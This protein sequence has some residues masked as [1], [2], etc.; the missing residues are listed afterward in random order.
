MLA[1]WRKLYSSREVYGPLVG[2]PDSM[3]LTP[4]FWHNLTEVFQ[5][6]ETALELYLTFVE[7]G[8]TP[9]CDAICQNTTICDLR[10]FRSENNCVSAYIGS[11]APISDEL[12]GQS[13][14]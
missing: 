11:R 10:A 6:N 8:V 2:L 4:A 5:R 3:P 14:N 9:E 13:N 1:V 7:R 12:E